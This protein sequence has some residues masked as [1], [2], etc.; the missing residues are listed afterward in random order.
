MR[1]Q[2]LLRCKN[3]TESLW[4]LT[5]RGSP[6]VGSSHEATGELLSGAQ[7][8]DVQNGNQKSVQLDNVDHNQTVGDREREKRILNQFQRISL[9]FVYLISLALAALS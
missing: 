5:N 4:R 1:S 6:Q 9:F 7:G 3:F 8:E 2:G